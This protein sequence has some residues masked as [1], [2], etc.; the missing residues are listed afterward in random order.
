MTMRGSEIL[1][2]AAEIRE[3]IGAG[4]RICNLTVGDFDPKQFPIPAFLEEQIA[5]ALH[6]RETNYPPSTGVPVLRTAVADFYGRAL[7]VAYQPESVLVTSGSRPAIYGS[8][9]TLVDPKD[10]VVFGVPSWNSNYYCH[11]VDAT[12]VSVTCD[13]SAAFLP[14]A[15]QLKAAVRGA[16]LLVLNSP[17]NPCGTAFDA[18]ALGAICDVVLEENASRGAGERP[19]Y[20][21]YDQVYWQLTFGDVTH[22]H[23]VDLRPAM[24][25]YTL[26][27]DGMSKAF[28][29]TGVRVGWLVGPPDIVR[30]A[31]DFLGHVGTW[32]PRAE[33]IASAELLG[34]PEIIASYRRDFIA[35]LEQRL[36]A[37]FKG[38]TALKND[39]FPVDAVAPMG[40]MYLSARF[41]LHGR[42]SASGDVMRTN[43]DVRRWLLSECGLAVVPFQAFGSS[44]DTGWFRLS[45]GAVSMEDIAVVLPRLQQAL[46]RLS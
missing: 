45:V 41:G 30:A 44:E 37:L 46:S 32:A 4:E 38:I 27:V 25:P 40:A 21:L 23:P 39:G 3:R 42:K 10:R 17:L 5:L 28:A 18:A 33:Q 19:L 22:V 6:R 1:R 26:Y 9:V 35:G 8:F 2:I 16:R 24:R 13:A 43:H 29:A 31:N 15:Q 36:D 11:L 34:R 12:P 14:N 20:L 7:G